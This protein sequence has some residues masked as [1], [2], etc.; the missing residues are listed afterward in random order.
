MN[1]R[2]E[3]TEFLHDGNT[4]KLT[5]KFKVVDYSGGGS[6]SEWVW[7]DASTGA[8]VKAGGHYHGAS[9]VT[10]YD[11]ISTVVDDAEFEVPE[12]VSCDNAAAADPVMREHIFAHDGAHLP[13]NLY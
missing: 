1:V 2:Y 3:Q 11:Q 10:M 12:R 9:S 5:G 13:K 8:W 7:L 4:T 6:G